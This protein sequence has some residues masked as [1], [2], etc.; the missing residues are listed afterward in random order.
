MPVLASPALI[1]RLEEVCVKAADHLLDASETTVGVGFDLVHVA[2]TPQGSE[3]RLTA[4]ILFRQ[5][6]DSDSV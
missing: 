4:H 5:V 1:G 3:V 6:T 2:P